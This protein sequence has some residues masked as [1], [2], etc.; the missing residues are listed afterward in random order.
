MSETTLL[1]VNGTL[2]RGLKLNP[3]ML[4]VGGR[5]VR[6]DHTDEHYRIWSVNDDHPGMMRVT[7]GGTAV[8][9]EVWELPMASFAALLLSEPAGLCIGKL[10]LRNGQ[11]ML[12]VLAEP[13]RIEG[14]L[15]ITRFGGWRAYMDQ[16]DR[17]GSAAFRI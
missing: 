2:M 12:G 16:Q 1:A 6:E 15:E 13:W 14:Q 3:N 4:N 5:F 9:L 8:A 11:E 17:A 7:E 10:Q